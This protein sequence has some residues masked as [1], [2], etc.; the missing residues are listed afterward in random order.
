MNC[1]NRCICLFTALLLLQFL[2]SFQSQGQHNNLVINGSFEEYDVDSLVPH[3]GSVEY[4]TG[5]HGPS[6]DFYGGKKNIGSFYMTFPYSPKFKASNGNIFAGL[7]VSDK[8][9]SEKLGGSLSSPLRKEFKYKL[10]FSFRS[11]SKSNDEILLRFFF[12]D[13]VSLRPFL[14]NSSFPLRLKGK[15]SVWNFF[16]MEFTCVNEAKYFILSSDQENPNTP[17]NYLYIDDF[18]IICLDSTNIIGRKE[19]LPSESSNPIQKKFVLP[20]DIAFK[21]NSSLISDSAVFILNTFAHS[22]ADDSTSLLI[23]GF[24][25][26]SGD[27]IFNQNLSKKRAEA[28]YNTLVSLGISKDRLQYEGLGSSF[29]IAPNDS[30]ENK[31]KNRRVEILICSKKE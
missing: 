21:T 23:K 4:L 25:D 5:W 2:F 8:L 11:L 16:T 6:V 18:R 7:S 20:N 29:P 9:R 14:F 17:V 10:S 24:T 1:G 19:L 12:S 15:P 31:S 13:T 30:P 28:V 27:S 22:I 26:S 3:N